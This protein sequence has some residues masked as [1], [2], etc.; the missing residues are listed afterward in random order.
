MNTQETMSKEA[1][2]HD[3]D[4]LITNRGYVNEICLNDGNGYF[5]QVLFFGSK[6]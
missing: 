4:I 2:T 5:Y 6:S 3:L 1:N